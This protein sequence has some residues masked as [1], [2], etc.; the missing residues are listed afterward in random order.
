MV[1]EPNPVSE[2]NAELIESFEQSGIAEG[3]SKARVSKYVLA[4]RKLANWLGKDFDKA[5]RKDIQWLVNGIEKREEYSAWTKHDYKV[6]VKR[7]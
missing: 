5:N 7:F 4:L 6:T 2:R 1:R 3:L